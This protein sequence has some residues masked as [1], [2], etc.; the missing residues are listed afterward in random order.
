MGSDEHARLRVDADLQTVLTA[1]HDATVRA[2]QVQEQLQAEV[3]RLTAALESQQHKLPR[4]ARS[5]DV[6]T[7]SARV[8]R[9]VRSSL[10]PVSLFL[11]LLRRRMLDDP[12]GLDLLHKA[13]RSC[14]TA[15]ARIDDLLHLTSELPPMLRPVNLRALVEDVHT[16]LRPRLLSLGVSTSVDIPQHATALADYDMLRQAV[17]NVT[18]NALDAMPSGGELVITSY[19]GA[20]AVELE[21]ADSGVGLSEDARYRAFEPFFSTHDGAGLGLTV[22]QR[23]LAAHGG[24]VTATNCAEGGAAV[25]LRIPR[26][27]MEAA[28]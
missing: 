22:V 8:A 1:W 9:G 13:E 26:R 24:T 5:D 10:A 6:A 4:M 15:D 7:T 16:N 11:N 27:A 18:L 19:T 17:H 28:A 3:R 20:G 14:A 2:E 25:T 23:L 12:Q 21:I